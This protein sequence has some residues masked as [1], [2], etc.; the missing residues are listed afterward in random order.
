MDIKESVRIETLKLLCKLYKEAFGEGS[1]NILYETIPNALFSILFT[2]DV[3]CRTTYFLRLDEFLFSPLCDD[4]QR[5]DRLEHVWSCLDDNGVLAFT[6][7]L[8]NKYGL[9]KFTDAF[10]NLLLNGGEE[11]KLRKILEVVFQ[12]IDEKGLSF[13]ETVKFIKDNPI[14]SSCLKT[15]LSLSSSMEQRLESIVKYF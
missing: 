11:S 9:V 5:A 10:L 8:R 14:I 12:K 6:A 3:S 7:F 1:S 2:Q 4:E 15:L 13:E